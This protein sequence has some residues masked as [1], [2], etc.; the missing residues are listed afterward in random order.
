MNNFYT[1]PSHIKSNEKSIKEPT[2]IPTKRRK[3]MNIRNAI[4]SMYYSYRFRGL[5]KGRTPT[6][7]PPPQTLS[8][9]TYLQFL[10]SPSWRHLFK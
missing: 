5:R 6:R 1:Q 10:L 2:E 8:S 3:N 4:I 9:K 7:L